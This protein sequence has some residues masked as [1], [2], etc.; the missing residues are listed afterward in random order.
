MIKTLILTPDGVGSTFLQRTMTAMYR[1]NGTPVKNIHELQTGMQWYDTGGIKKELA[2]K[3]NPQSLKE[4]QNILEK[5]NEDIIAVCA[6]RDNRLHPDKDKQ[7]FYKFCN[8]FFDTKIACFRKNVF[9]YALSWSIRNKTAITNTYSI[10]D[11]KK[12][13]QPKSVDIN[14]FR[15]KCDHYISY[16]FWL[17]EF[18]ENYKKVWYEDIVNDADQVL[19][20]LTGKNN[21]WQ[22]Q[23]G[24]TL[25]EFIKFEY[26]MLQ[27]YIDKNDIEKHYK[28]DKF[29]KFVH[30]RKYFKE[31]EGAEVLT[32]T[33]PIKNTSLE[34]KRKIVLNYEQCQREY[35]NF[36]KKHNMI[37]GSCKSYDF[38]QEKEL[39]W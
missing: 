16:L 27:D 26:D 23:F 33:L 31:L 1:L 30:V 11:K 38:W 15:T 37:D 14:F 21:V 32:R 36:L 7:E 5:T 22:D 2:P 39:D 13:Q 12:V 35:D 20:G 17:D 9:E 25:N 29:K 34:L 19:Q 4:I 28:D 8:E 10:E 24:I 3:G 18:F 6:P